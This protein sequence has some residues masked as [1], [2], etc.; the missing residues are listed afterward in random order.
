MVRRSDRGILA[1]HGGR[2]GNV[3]PCPQTFVCIAKE[4]R[5]RD[6]ALFVRG[7][8]SPDFPAGMSDLYG[9]PVHIGKVG[10]RMVCVGGDIA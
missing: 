9:L 10:T 1:D 5:Q 6:C 2:Y 4:N 3:L 8:C 7:E